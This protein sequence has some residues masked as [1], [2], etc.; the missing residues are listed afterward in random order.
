[1]LAY[2]KYPELSEA[3]I[4]ALVVDD[5]WMAQLSGAIH[6][7]LDSASQALTSR[8]CELAQRYSIP[9]PKLTDD[10]SKLAARVELHLESMGMKWL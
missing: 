1:M 2:E 6:G 10:L 5:K 8:I 4:K 9:L 7:E 3:E